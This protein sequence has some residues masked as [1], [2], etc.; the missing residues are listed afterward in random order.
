MSISIPES[1]Y[2]FIGDYQQAHH[3]KTRSEVITKALKT[4][5]QLHLEGFYLQANQEMEQDFDATA[6]DG[7]EDETW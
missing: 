5:Q 6:G 3:Y 7:L 1:I 4:L 2:D